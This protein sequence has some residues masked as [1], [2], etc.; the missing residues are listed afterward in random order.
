MFKHEQPGQ[1]TQPGQ[2]RCTNGSIWN[3]SQEQDRQD[4]THTDYHAPKKLTVY[5][6]HNETGRLRGILRAVGIHSSH[7]G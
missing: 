7:S 3:Q 1:G 2:T 4:V 6:A 5:P